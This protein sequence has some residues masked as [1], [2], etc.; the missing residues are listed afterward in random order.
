MLSSAGAVVDN[1][2]ALAVVVVE[3]ALQKIAKSVVGIVLVMMMLVMVMIT[4][5]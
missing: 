3:Q 4:S 2:G 5:S 1:M